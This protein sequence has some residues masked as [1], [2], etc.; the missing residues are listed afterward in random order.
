MAVTYA[1]VSDVATRLGRPISDTTEVAQVNAWL[2]DVEGMIAA[3]VGS[4]SDAITAGTIT[5]ST[6]LRVECQVVI[7]KITNPDGKIAED[8]DDY[9]Y[10]YSE[11]A[12]RGE[13][14]L[15]DE[16]WADLTPGSPSAAFTITPYGVPGASY[17]PEWVAEL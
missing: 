13:L 9:R 15:T 5:P 8:I 16:E 14:F 7:R 3:R 12:R 2:G 10:R 11:N 6:L 17:E 1:T 4:L